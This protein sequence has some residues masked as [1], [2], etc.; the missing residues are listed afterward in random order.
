MSV[1]DGQ[2]WPPNQ[3]NGLVSVCRCG[4]AV[5]LEV[6]SGSVLLSVAQVEDLHTDLERAVHSLVVERRV[7]GR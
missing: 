7:H 4:D 1:V 2:T 3:T 5:L 6:G